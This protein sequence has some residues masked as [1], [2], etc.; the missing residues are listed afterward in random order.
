MRP[1]DP[2]ESWF[3]VDVYL[4][5]AARN[6]RVIPQHK[7]HGYRIDLVVETPRDRVAVECDG[8][9]WHGPDRIEAD[10]GRQRELERCGWTFYRVPE[11]RFRLDAEE[12]LA[13][14]WRLLESRER[15]SEGPT[16]PDLR[17]WASNKEES[18]DEQ[19]EPELASGEKLSGAAPTPSA[20]NEA[21]S[22]VG[23][24]TTHK[25]GGG[26]SSKLDAPQREGGSVA[27]AA[28]ERQEGIGYRS[29][30]GLE[31]YS[32]WTT[33]PLPD[34]LTARP[35][36][37]IEGLIEIVAVEGPVLGERLARLFVV[38]AG[39]QR[40]G[41]RLRH[42]I[43]NAVRRAVRAGQLAILRD[44]GSTDFEASVVHLP[45]RPSVRLRERGPRS[46]EEIPSSE[47]E[48]MMALLQ[49]QAPSLRGDSLNRLVVSSFGFG[50]MT[51]NMHIRLRA[52]ASHRD[53]ARGTQQS[54]GLDPVN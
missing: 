9:Q 33:R 30:R 11:S 42:E 7:V 40:A 54:L 2:F 31:P 50:R 27:G 10:L 51:E 16:R 37:L 13:D 35:G 21:G 29:L 18:P 46:F 41:K 34:P 17:L 1:P 53:A 26:V 32:T 38:A 22:L 39:G 45:D 3:E 49:K 19:S 52:I 24:S 25:S 44:F 20:D 12:A 43:A 47:I 48:Q 36:D 8:S 4:M 28:G 5:L 6:Y 23:D 14:L 15:S